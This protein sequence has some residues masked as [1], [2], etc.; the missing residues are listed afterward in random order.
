MIEAISQSRNDMLDTKKVKWMSYTSAQSNGI[1][2]ATTSRLRD[3]EFSIVLASRDTDEDFG[4]F[5]WSFSS[6]LRLQPNEIVL[7]L[8]EP[9]ST[10][11]VR[12]AIG[13]CKQFRFKDLNIVEV[14]RSS[15]WNFHQ[16]KVH[17]V[18]YLNSKHD[19]ML[20]YDIDTVLFPRVLRGLEYVGK[21]NVAAVSFGKFL[22]ADSFPS[23]VRTLYYHTRRMFIPGFTGIYWLYRPYYL[24]LMPEELI[25]TIHNGYD[26]LLVNQLFKQREY[27]LVKLRDVGCYCL[28]HQNEDLPW[29]QFQDGVWYGANR[30]FISLDGTVRIKK[31]SWIGVCLKTFLLARPHI[32]KGYYWAKENRNSFVTKLARSVTFEKF[33]YLGQKYFQGYGSRNAA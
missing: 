32:L 7:C 28:T 26:A 27:R 6:A 30:A 33:G 13:I 31:K 16:A 1:Q 3:T 20:A 17:H 23:Y 11:I 29:R 12:C 10:R 15:D 8:D 9:A 5:P 4:Y 18:G 25:K 14:Q 2:H 21:D 19:R 22:R 24:E